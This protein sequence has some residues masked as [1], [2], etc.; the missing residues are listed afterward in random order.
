MDQKNNKVME[1]YSS[2]F[3]ELPPLINDMTYNDAI[4][5]QL[6]S[7]AVYVSLKPITIEDIKKEMEKQK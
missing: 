3:G 5:A 6:M 2:M 4:Y 7:R 1:L